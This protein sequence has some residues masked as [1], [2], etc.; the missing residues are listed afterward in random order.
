MMRFLQRSPRRRPAWA[1]WLLL[2]C[3]APGLA[4]EEAFFGFM[5]L[6]DRDPARP[7]GTTTFSREFSPSGSA[8]DPEANERDVFLARLQHRQGRARSWDVRIGLGGQIYSFRGPFGESIP[9]QTHPWMR[10]EKVRNMSV[11]IDE[12]WQSVA[13]CSARMN[14]DRLYRPGARRAPQN[15]ITAMAYFIHQA[16]VYL[17]DPTLEKPY[18]SPLLASHWDEAQRTFSTVTW[19]QQANPPSLHRSSSLFYTRYR[20]CG[21]GVLEVTRGLYN[22]GEDTL[23]Y[24]NT[25]WGGVRTSSLPQQ[26]Y[27]DADGRAIRQRC[28][29]GRNGI[30][31]VR[32]S[33][34]YFYWAQEGEDPNRF[35]LG[36]VFG[37][38]RRAAGRP[39]RLRW[40]F[41]GANHLRDYSVFTVNACPE[42]ERGDFFHWRSYF[43]IGRLAHVVRRCRA[44]VPAADH[45][46]VS[47]G[48]KRQPVPADPAAPDGVPRLA[49]P[50]AHSLPLVLMRDRR[51]GREFAS[52]DLYALTERVPFP[53]PY[54]GGH[55]KHAR[56]ADRVTVRT[57]RTTEYVRLL[58]FVREPVPIPSAPPAGG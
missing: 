54:P 53:N 12:V 46:M 31:A 51:T 2:A 42:V 17:R 33:G 16:G 50:T 15:R 24:L 58:G 39:A 47:P 35:A 25:P 20:D 37:R 56:Y 3:V 43:V 22:F 10:R 8:W 41:A 55:P 14:H 11:W 19:G 23:D 7:A 40:G 29:F 36:L 13:V 28:R 34:G 44:L 57:H 30:A 6:P 49:W 38:E 1:A 18:Y 32:E 27:V 21:D 5:P 26:W 4:G 9:P 48:G 52:T 45:G